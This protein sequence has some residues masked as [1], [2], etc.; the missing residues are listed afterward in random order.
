MIM[1]NVVSSLCARNHLVVVSNILLS[2]KENF[3]TH[4]HPFKYHGKIVGETLQMTNLPNSY[5]CILVDKV[6]L[7]KWSSTYTCYM[8]Q[9]VEVWKSLFSFPLVL[10]T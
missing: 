5:I 1:Y 8:V 7:S 6:L 9:Y 4:L 3:N 2:L 10:L